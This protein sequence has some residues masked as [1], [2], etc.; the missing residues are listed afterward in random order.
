MTTHKK[1]FFIVLLLYAFLRVATNLPAIQKPRELADTTAYLRVSRQPLQSQNF[2]GGARP[3]VFPLLLKISSQNLSAAA[4]T[5]LAISILAWGFLARAVGAS[6]RWGYLEIASSGLIL[7]LSLLPR[8]SGWDYV[9]MTESLS[10]S[11]F[12][13]FLALGVWLAQAWKAY[14]IILL[15]LGAF[16]LAFTRDTNA[17]LLLMQ[18]GLLVAAVLFRRASPRALMLAASFVVIFLLNNASADLGGRWVF[19]LNNNIGKRILTNADALQYFENCGMPVTPELLSLADSFANGQER[20]F[21]ESPALEG[22]RAWLY[23]EGKPCYMKYLL[24]H[25]LQSAGAALRQFQTLM[26]FEKVQKYFARSYDPLMPYFFEP[27][28]YPIFFILPLWVSLTGL[29]LYAAWKKRWQ[30]SPLWA[31]YVLL[32]LPIFPHLFVTW[33]GDA[34]APERHALSVG[35]QLALSFWLAL[36]LL[37]E[38][39]ARARK[40]E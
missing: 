22:Y 21:Y 4:T 9:M 33:H 7:A 37:V 14:K 2:W 34:M 6:F 11:F 26:S 23:A 38:E 28:F 20:A 27:F 12:V 24:A 17:Y 31:V 25:P 18:A 5:Q 35:L 39:F 1:I 32:C 40:H 36:F 16:F 10:V 15:L 29:A 30:A 3:F 13:L 19:P 8:L